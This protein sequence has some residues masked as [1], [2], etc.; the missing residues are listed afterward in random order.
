M[1]HFI[2]NKKIKDLFNIFVISSIVISLFIISSPIFDKGSIIL[3]ILP[4]IMML[5][6][7][8]KEMNTKVFTRT[9]KVVVTLLFIYYLGLFGLIKY[10]DVSRNDYIK[11]Q[12]ENGSNV[13]EVKA[14]PTYYIWRYNPSDYF[15]VK[16]FKEYYEIGEHSEIDLKYFGLFEEIEKQI[17]KD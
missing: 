6:I 7:L 3:I 14:S 4:F 2:T 8:A 5:C 15:L 9:I 12:I 10:I 11:E 13:I 1:N 17:K 16:D